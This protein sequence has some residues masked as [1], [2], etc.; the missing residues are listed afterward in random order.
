MSNVI[1]YFSATGNNLVVARKIAEQ[2][3]DTKLLKIGL[4][5]EAIDTT[6]YERVGIVF[7]VYYYQPPLFVE[8]FVKKLIFK[9]EQYKFA[10]VAHGPCRGIA[11]ENI[12]NQI[13]TLG[14]ILDGEFSVFLPGNSITEY[15][16]VPAY[17]NILYRKSEKTIKNI[18][19]IVQT[20]QSTEALGPGLFE[21]LVLKNEK[22]REKV[23]NIRQKFLEYD[24][25]FNYNQNCN[26][27]GTCVKVCPVQNIHLESGHPVWEHKCQQCTACIQ[28]CPNSSI[29]FYN[30]T[31]KRKRYHHKE[32]TLKDMIN[33]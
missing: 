2:L 10:V 11:L 20:K 3:G 18:V 21:R 12:R 5:Q 31:Q 32:V 8:N 14:F 24:S 17:H 13:N 6:P 7:P 33:K 29:N 25:G 26:S 19:N 30:K 4:S 28:W 27:C 16:D 23:M 22:L 9:K 15:G 1:Y